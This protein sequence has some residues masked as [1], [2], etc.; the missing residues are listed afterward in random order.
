MSFPS[1]PR[2]PQD[3]RGNMGLGPTL[4]QAASPPA[5]DGGL[6]VEVNSAFEEIASLRGLVEELG[7]RLVPVRRTDE[8]DTD[9]PASPRNAHAAPLALLVHDLR[10]QIVSAHSDLL[11]IYRSLDL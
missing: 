7:K 6:C 9:R 10:A 3:V 1:S 8:T 2:P 5:P 11:A 4:S